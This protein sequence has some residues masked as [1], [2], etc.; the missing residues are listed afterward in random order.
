MYEHILKINTQS[1]RKRVFKQE[2]TKKGVN[3]AGSRDNK[4]NKNISKKQS[5]IKE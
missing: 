2:K 3:R 1:I 4:K 5:N